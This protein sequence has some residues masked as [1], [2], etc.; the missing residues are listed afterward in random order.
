MEKK[1]QKIY[2]GI[3]LF[4]LVAAVLIVVLH[5]IETTSWYSNEVKFVITRFAVPFFFIA[6]GFFSLKD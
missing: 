5:A 6:S 2:S 3:D 1:E 4:K